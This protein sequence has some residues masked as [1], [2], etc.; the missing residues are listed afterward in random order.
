ML[1][2]LLIQVKSMCII[3]R[4]QTCWLEANARKEQKHA[5]SDLSQELEQSVSWHPGGVMEEQGVDRPPLSWP[6]VRKASTGPCASDIR[7][8]I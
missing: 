5:L 6:S 8:A 2:L 7:K 4:R 1:F 3:K